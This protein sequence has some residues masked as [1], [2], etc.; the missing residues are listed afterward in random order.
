MKKPNITIYKSEKDDTLTVQIDTNNLPEDKNGPVIRVYLN[1][2]T[3]YE[4]PEYHSIK[5]I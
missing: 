4:N 5:E 1:D 2:S 3:I